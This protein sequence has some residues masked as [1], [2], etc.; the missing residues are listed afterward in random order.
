MIKTKITSLTFNSTD[1]QNKCIKVITNYNENFKPGTILIS[2]KI[3][4]FKKMFYRFNLSPFSAFHIPK[5]NEYLVDISTSN[6]KRV[7]SKFPKIFSDCDTLIKSIK[8][9]DTYESSVFNNT[10]IILDR[11]SSTDIMDHLDILNVVYNLKI[12][13]EKCHFDGKEVLIS[14]LL[15]KQKLFKGLE[16]EFAIQLIKDYNV[17]N[18]NLKFGHIEEYKK[19]F[20]N[21]FLTSKF[22]EEKLYIEY[23]NYFTKT[24]SN[25]IDLVELDEIINKC[26]QINVNKSLTFSQKLSINFNILVILNSYSNNLD[27]FKDKLS[28]P[29]IEGLFFGLMIDFRKTSLKNITKNE[30]VE[31]IFVMSYYSS[32]YQTELHWQNIN[33]L[34]KINKFSLRNTLDYFKIVKTLNQNLKYFDYKFLLENFNFE[35]ICRLDKNEVDRFIIIYEYFRKFEFFE[36]FKNDLIKKSYDFIEEEITKDTSLKENFNYLFIRLNDLDNDEK[37]LEINKLIEKIE[38]TNEKE[39]IGND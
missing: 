29:K 19:L 20:I 13:S 5:H 15:N 6:L 11:L 21:K 39:Q 2:R 38:N 30:I 9:S 12:L 32:K 10:R 26:F 27:F 34:I 35:E 14:F 36:I 24:F 18:N 31:L 23:L 4:K 37:F 28:L 25:N 22:D 7:L 17:L 3:I 16:L 1:L 8:N 33:S